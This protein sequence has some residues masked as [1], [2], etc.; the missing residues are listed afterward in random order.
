MTAKGEIL[1]FTI[2]NVNFPTITAADGTSS[3]STS[4]L[5]DSPAVLTPAMF[6]LDM[7]I[8]LACVH[9]GLHKYFTPA[10]H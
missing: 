6:Q 4:K 2:I 9:K 7:H 3:T 10:L 1:I 8:P 5:D